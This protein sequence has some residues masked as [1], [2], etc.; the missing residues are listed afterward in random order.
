[1]LILSPKKS[2]AFN[3]QN[4]PLI[5]CHLCGIVQ[6]LCLAKL[7]FVSALTLPL[8]YTFKF[9]NFDAASFTDVNQCMTSE[10]LVWHFTKSLHFYC[11]VKEL[12]TGYISI[13]SM[14]ILPL[15]RAKFR[16][17]KTSSCLDKLFFYFF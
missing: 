3:F 16:I 5:T 11:L 8:F 9:C 2:Y 6:N 14:P 12:R 13:Y 15:K 4:M 10:H 1:M 7:F 17:S